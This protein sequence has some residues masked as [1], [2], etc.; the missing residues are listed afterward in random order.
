[1]TDPLSPALPRWVD[2]PGFR[3]DDN[4]LFLPAPGDGTLRAVMDWSAAWGA[5][6]LP[7]DR[8]PWRCVR[9]DGVEVDGTPGRTVV[10][11][12]IH[13]AL[14][15]AG[16]A[17]RMFEEYLRFDPDTPLA[18][19]PPAE[20]VVEDDRVAAWRAGWADEAR[21]AGRLARTGAQRA[22]RAARDPRH[23]KGRVTELVRAARRLTDPIGPEPLSPLLR[24]T[25]ARMR[26]D[27]LPVDLAA[28]KAG[29]RAA[30]G[31]VNDGVMTAV[32]LG[33]RQWHLDH[34]VRLPAV[35]TAMAVSTRTPR[36]AWRGNAVLAVVV[37]LPVDEHDPHELLAQCRAISA[38]ARDDEDA[39]WLMDRTR[40]ASNRLPMPLATFASKQ[41]LKGLDVSISNIASVPQRTWLAHR[42]QLRQIPFVVGTLSAFGMIM[43]SRSG[44]CDIGITTCPE[45]IR[46][47]DHFVRRL[48]EGFRQVAEL[49]SVSSSLT[50]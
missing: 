30:G 41:S 18:P 3:T 48:D 22:R 9:F 42:E 38:A 16:G 29:A 19:L 36:D 25:S 23:A 34:G 40:A 20:P 32:S 49:G 44:R 12:Q 39:L 35:R 27:V 37:E 28:L 15:D 33:L 43:T 7:E 13:H 24:R 6:P 2:V 47:P 26:F 10:V 21:R 46:D 45:A 4:W 11:S 17:R 1:V 50:A 31:S 5:L 14:I 8:P